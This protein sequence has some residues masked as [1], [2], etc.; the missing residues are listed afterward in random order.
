M[1]SGVEWRNSLLANR[2]NIS[3][4]KVT[5]DMRDGLQ[6]DTMHFEC[7]PQSKQHIRSQT[8]RLSRAVTLITTRLLPAGRNF[9]EEH[10]PC[11]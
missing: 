8:S 6:F 4:N 3:W 11:R 1:K 5:A 10:S 2:E 9:E 7:S